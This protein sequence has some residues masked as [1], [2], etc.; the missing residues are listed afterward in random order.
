MYHSGWTLYRWRQPRSFTAFHSMTNWIVNTCRGLLTSV[1]GNIFSLLD[2][3]RFRDR[4]CFMAPV[5]SAFFR[6]Q[7][8]RDTILLTLPPKLKLWWAPKLKL[9][10]T[11]IS[12]YWAD[13]IADSDTVVFGAQVVFSLPLLWTRLR[14]TCSLWSIMPS[15][16]ARWFTV[17][18]DD[19]HILARHRDALTNSHSLCQRRHV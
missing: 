10:L 8:T 11:S 6:Q 18:E 14:R 12:L 16:Y 4:T 3:Q 2:T 19:D 15:A 5:K 17:C 7:K 1:F 13:T 9:W